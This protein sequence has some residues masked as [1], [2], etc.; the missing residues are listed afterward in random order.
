VSGSG[1]E[2][3]A[4]D[5]HWMDRPRCIAAWRIRDTL[6]D[7]GPTTTLPHLLQALDGWQP[8]RL[9]LTHIH[10]D[11]AGAAGALA[12]EWP[13]L[14]I[15][16][17]RRGARHMASPERLEASARR[18]FGDEFDA[19][20]GTLV[21]I[22]EERLHPLDG[23]EMIDGLRIASTPG[24]ASHHVCMFDDSS[25]WA[26]VGDV[27]GVRLDP[28]EP[29]FAPSPP[30]DIDVD[31]WLASVALVAGWRPTRLGITHY[32]VVDDPEPHLTA[33]TDDLHREAELIRGGIAVDD[34]VKL[35]TDVLVAGGA[36]DRVGDYEL[37]V[38]LRQNHAGLERWLERHGADSQV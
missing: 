23:G 33:I 5:V 36:R 24:H 7:C 14:E 31:Q 6:I 35:M 29:V 16:V 27:A 22:E 3:T 18:V 17:H 28:G 37:T 26:F 34:Y 8:R 1:E 15:Y 30:P 38:P 9:I 11:H 10:F 2:V 32:G 4:V 19:R 25:G 13:D 21:P 20:F 12:R